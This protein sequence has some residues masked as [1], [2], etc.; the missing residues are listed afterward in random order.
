[1]GI[2]IH[3]HIYTHVHV[4]VAMYTTKNVKQSCDY[5]ATMKACLDIQAGGGGGVEQ[6]F[7]VA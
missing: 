5:Y 2:Y 4:Y 7:V 6:A 1:M 3:V